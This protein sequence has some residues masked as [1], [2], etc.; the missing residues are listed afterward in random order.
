[1]NILHRTA[2]VLSQTT[3]GNGDHVLCERLL[4]SYLRT[5]N[6]ADATPD[7]L[8]FYTE[9]VKLCCEGSLVLSELQALSK[10]GAILILCRTCLEHYKLMDAVK[11]GEIGNML[12]IL[13]A[14]AA[15]AKVIVL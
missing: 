10:K 9:G 1:M 6:E 5:L 7:F 2:I 14:Q 15:A 13:E 12:K 3:M 4:H 8:L 11:V